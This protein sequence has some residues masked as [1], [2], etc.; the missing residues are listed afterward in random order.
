MAQALY[1]EHPLESYLRGQFLSTTMRRALPKLLLLLALKE[2]G[3]RRARVPGAFS[4]SSDE[5]S[6][7]AID[8]TCVDP[9]RSRSSVFLALEV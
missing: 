8:V 9:R 5:E 1:D 2:S 7:G 6:E 4:D 3:D